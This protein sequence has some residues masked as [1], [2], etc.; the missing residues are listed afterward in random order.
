MASS[1]PSQIPTIIYLIQQ[2]K[3]KTVLDIGKGFGKYGFLIH[4]YVG[5]DKQKQLKPGLSMAAQSNVSVDAIEVDKD[6]L[7]PHLSQF[8][9]EIFVGDVF[10]IYDKIGAYELVIMID[11]I[12]HLNKEKALELLKYFISKG[13]KIIIATPIDFFEQKLYE[14][15]YENHIS[16]W[17][18]RDF[19]KIG[20]VECQFFNDAAVYLLTGNKIETRGFGNSFMKKLKRVARTIKNEL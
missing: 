17:Q 12:E 14:S 7:L 19:E 5:I 8:Y 18:K 10:D 6:L 20:N 2:L 1:F 13:T 11:V 3:P 15:E 9:N 4:E 16:H